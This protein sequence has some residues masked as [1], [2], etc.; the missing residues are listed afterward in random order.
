M[1]IDAAGIKNTRNL[2][3]VIGEVDVFRLAKLNL[4]QCAI[5]NLTGSSVCIRPHNDA[6]EDLVV[7]KCP[8][9]LIDRGHAVQQRDNDS[10]LV[11]A[12]CHVDKGRG[13]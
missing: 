11:D 3:H 13:E 7:R 12:G 10:F 2:L 9:Y 4:A 6:V 5:G 8:L 1:I